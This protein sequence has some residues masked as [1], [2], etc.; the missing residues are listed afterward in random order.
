M[1][2]VHRKLRALALRVLAQIPLIPAKAGIQSFFCL[3]LDPRFRGDERLKGTSV[4]PRHAFAAGKGTA[5]WSWR[6]PTPQ[7]PGDT[8]WFA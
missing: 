6:S 5:N 2:T 1:M 7:H 4:K 8:P 3:A